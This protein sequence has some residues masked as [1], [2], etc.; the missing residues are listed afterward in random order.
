[1]NISESGLDLIKRHEGWVP[2]AY[3]CPAGWWTIGYGHVI[4]KGES[5][6]NGISK[7]TGEK[8]LQADLAI[9][10]EAVQ[11]LTLAELNQPMFEALVSFTY[12]LGAGNYKASTLRAK[13]NRGDYEGA[14]LQFGRWTLAGGRKLPGLIIRRADEAALFRVGIEKITGK[15]YVFP[16]LRR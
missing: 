14:L 11:R 15:G 16:W 9:A 12:N 2:T 4:K 3:K 7:M 8:L 6:P 1:M 13:L 10:C 5:F